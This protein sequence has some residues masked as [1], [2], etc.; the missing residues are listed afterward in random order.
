MLELVRNGIHLF[1]SE[2]HRQQVGILQ[3]VYQNAM[4]DAG[5]HL[6]L[7]DENQEQVGILQSAMVDAGDHVFQKK[8]VCRAAI[9]SRA[10]TEDATWHT[11]YCELLKWK[12][13]KDKDVSV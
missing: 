3:S 9:D 2:T 7:S 12:A 1:L 6:F 11:H 8:E 13:E 4:V 10:Q 5:D